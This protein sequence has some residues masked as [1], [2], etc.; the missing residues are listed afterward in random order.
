M[1]SLIL[2][3]MSL[4]GFLFLVS[5]GG[6]GVCALNVVFRGGI[7]GALNATPLRWEEA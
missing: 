4:V 2:G 7:V 5:D 1:V 3:D 6:N